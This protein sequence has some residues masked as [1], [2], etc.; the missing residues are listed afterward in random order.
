M[1]KPS[2]SQLYQTLAAPQTLSARALVDADTAVRAAQGRVVPHEREEVAA[3][4][5]GSSAHSD[6][7]QFLK[8][9]EP[10]SAE[11]ASSLAH[12]TAA[13]ESRGHGRRSA[14]SRPSRPAWRWGAVAASLVAAVAFFVADNARHPAAPP[15]AAAKHGDT[16]FNGRLDGRVAQHQVLEDR[17]FQAGTDG[18]VIDRIFTSRTDG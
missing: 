12:G 3:A 7:V 14:R 5:A 2:L 4:L 10:A 18:A 1:T 17:I 15:V 13:H 11:L 8:A 16:I 6:L 9:L